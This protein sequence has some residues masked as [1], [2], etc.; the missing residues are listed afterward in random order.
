MASSVHENCFIALSRMKQLH[1]IAIVGSM[2][3][4]QREGR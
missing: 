4:A 1:Q 3:A 2:A